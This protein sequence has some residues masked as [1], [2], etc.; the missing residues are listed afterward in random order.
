[1][2]TCEREG[3]KLCRGKNLEVGEAHCFILAEGQMAVIAGT[4]DEMVAELVAANKSRKMVLLG[5]V[6]PKDGKGSAEGLHHRA[7]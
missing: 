2:Y 1:M 6:G 5:K 7:I 4:N 3:N